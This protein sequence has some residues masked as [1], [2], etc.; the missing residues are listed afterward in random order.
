MNGLRHCF[1][2]RQNVLF[3]MMSAGEVA[4]LVK[5]AVQCIDD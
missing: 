3:H 1:G 5:S 4:L 2:G